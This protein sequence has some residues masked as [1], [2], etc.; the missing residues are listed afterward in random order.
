MYP[1]E[2]HGLQGKQSNQ[3]KPDVMNDFLLFVDNNG[4]PNGRQSD[5]HCPTFFFLPKFRR[6]D[7][8]KP[9]E[10]NY[11]EK[12]TYCLVSEFNRA[13]QSEGKGMA[14]SYA[15]RQWLKAHRPKVAIHPHK[16]D[17]CDTCKR[18]ETELS[19]LRQIV[20][21]LRQSGS[22][23]AE[24]V[25]SY[26]RSISDIDEELRR[27]KLGATETQTFY[28]PTTSKCAENWTSVESLA[29]K[30]SRSSKEQQELDTKKHAFTL[31][32]SADYQQSKLIPYWGCSAQSGSTYYLQKVSHHV[33]GIVDL[34]D[35]QQYTTLFDE[36]IRPKNTDHTISILQAHLETIT[37]RHPWINNFP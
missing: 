29:A 7:P 1:H 13:Q 10:K 36:R 6:V 35:N 17:H 27:H 34:H 22:A 25:Q 14:G 28:C 16:V 18:L 15:I 19:R 21:Q 9:S 5:S 11:D 12:M 24:D 37:G 31:V 33:F 20:K 23:S 8:P 3:A 4:T 30:T 32:V 2:Q 26:D